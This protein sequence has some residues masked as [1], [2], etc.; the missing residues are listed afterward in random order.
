LV[1]VNLVK[2][3]QFEPAFLEIAPN[4]KMPAIVD[5]D[6]IDGGKPISIFESGVIL[7]Y[8]AEKTG[9]LA[10]KDLRGRAPFRFF[11]ALYSKAAGHTTTGGF[12]LS[13]QTMPRCEQGGANGIVWGLSNRA[14]EPIARPVRPTK[15]TLNALARKSVC[16]TM[17]LD[18]P[19]DLAAPLPN[20]GKQQM[21]TG[22]VAHK[23]LLSWASPNA[24]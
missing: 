13:P 3:E 1:P 14:G 12:A 6:P 19:A 20:S 8:L 4:N 22:A 10:P 9:Q 16:A 17:E 18:R 23:A 21:I 7:Q 2:N 5:H 24:I 11:R 15:H